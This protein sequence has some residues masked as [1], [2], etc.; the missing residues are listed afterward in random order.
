MSPPTPVGNGEHGAKKARAQ[1]PV[2]VV[3]QEPRQEVATEEREEGEV[4]RGG[5]GGQGAAAAAA[6]AAEALV[7]V[8]PGPPPQIDVRVDQALLHCH[9]CLLPLKPPVFKVDHPRFVRD[10]TNR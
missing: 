9:A 2:P 4:A 7:A 3:K 1:E 8:V 6:S 5:G 10:L